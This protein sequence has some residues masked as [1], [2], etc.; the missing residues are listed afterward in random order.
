MIKSGWFKLTFVP[1]AVL[2][3]MSALANTENESS[4][5]IGAGQDWLSG[6]YTDWSLGYLNYE[7]Q[8]SPDWLGYARYQRTERFSQFDNEWFVGSYFRI[9]ELWQ[10]QLE[11][12]YSS[13]KRVR[14]EYSVNGYA[15]RELGNGYIASIGVHRNSWSSSTSQGYSLGLERY[16]NRW[17]WAYRIRYEQLQAGDGDGLSHQASLSYYYR[18]RSH[19]TVALNAGDEIEKI[20]ANEI[21]ATSVKGIALYGLHELNQSW[22]W[23]WAF[24]FQQQGDYYDRIGTQFG[25]RYH[26]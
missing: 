23:R 5:E 8:I 15:S 4:F 21:V 12:S 13:T 10:S 18:E 7:R 2:I 9:N 20:N 6:N 14:P 1:I 22:D 16:I 24:N 11:V 3:S 25:V 17:R 19:W 26:F